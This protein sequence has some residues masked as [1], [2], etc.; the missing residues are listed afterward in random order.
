M[1]SDRLFSLTGPKGNIEFL[2]L[3][4][5]SGTAGGTEVL[6][7]IPHIVVWRT[8]SGLMHIFFKKII[9]ILEI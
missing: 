3:L 7:D 4:E 8:V 2:L 9:F 5:K 1:T 6:A